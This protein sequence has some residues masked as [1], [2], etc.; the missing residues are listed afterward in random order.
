[1]K[2]IKFATS[3]CVEGA[4]QM[5]VVFTDGPVEQFEFEDLGKFIKV[6]ENLNLTLVKGLEDLEKKFARDG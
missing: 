6:L 1:M 3:S 2:R 4:V 5:T